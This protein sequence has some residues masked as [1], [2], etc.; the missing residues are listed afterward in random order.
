L[1]PSNVEDDPRFRDRVGIFKDRFHAGRLLAEKLSEYAGKGKSATIVVIP[2]GGVPVGCAM[3][4]QL[5]IPF[6]VMLVRKIPIPWEPEAG[7]GSV[8]F[9]GSTFL[10]ERLVGKLG[11]SKS[12]INKC[13]QA[14]KAGLEERTKKFLAIKKGGLLANISHKV[15]ILVDDGLASG[16]TMLAST[17][18][19]K[20]RKPSKIIVAV[21]TASLTA[22]HLVS[23]SVDT[24]L[25]LNLR[26]SPYFA[27]ADAYENWYDVPGEEALKLVESHSTIY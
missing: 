17:E 23:P 19:I 5:H 10:N 16:Y 24:L 13:I 6:D 12:E 15:V 9:D 7:F 3:A 1:I 2:S 21:P 20:K 11:L 4:E 8:T 22:V 25:C 26:S 18:S 27:V 14:A